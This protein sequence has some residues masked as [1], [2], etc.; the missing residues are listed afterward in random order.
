MIALI[1]FVLAIL[2]SPWRSKNRLEAENPALRQQL[3][4]LQQRMNG[5][6][7]LTNTIAVFCPAESMVPVDPHVLTIIRPETSVR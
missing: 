7:Q 1:R 4:D 3:I 2:G 6:A 5:R